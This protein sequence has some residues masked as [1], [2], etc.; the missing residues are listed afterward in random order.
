MAE[1]QGIQE[2]C[3]VLDELNNKYLFKATTI[4]KDGTSI[5]NDVSECIAYDIATLL[6]LDCAKYELCIKDGIK[7]VITPDFLNNETF[8]VGEE[9]LI[10]GVT[11]INLID[12]E[13]KNMSLLNPKT[14]QYYTVSLILESIEKY[15]FINNVLEYL[16]FDLLIA[17]RDRNPSNY[18]IIVNHKHNTIKLAPLFDNS[19]SLGVSINESKLDKYFENNI[20]KD[21]N[22]FKY[23]LCEHIKHKVTIERFSQLK[24]KLVWDKEEM[25]RVANLIE[26]SKLKLRP[27]LEEGLITNE[28]YLKR[29]DTIARKRRRYDISTTILTQQFNHIATY[30]YDE[31]Y[32]IMKRI[33]NFNDEVINNIL[34]K[35]KDHLPIYKYNTINFLLKSRRDYMLHTYSNIK[36]SERW[37]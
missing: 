16:V 2:K 4:R 36:E 29:L 35:Y 23:V 19:T 1:P 8:N 3:W 15:G 6:N 12:P 18:G 31:I 28:M 22:E 21:E 34:I 5:D 37:R 10:D 7:G 9:E 20:I 13:F 17:N 11:L 24:E 30:Y 14:K 32:E 33:E 25:N 27:M 26:E